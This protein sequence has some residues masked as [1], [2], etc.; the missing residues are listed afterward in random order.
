M[1]LVCVFCL[2]DYLHSLHSP[3]GGHGAARR[4]SGAV[5]TLAVNGTINDTINTNDDPK[6]RFRAGFAITIT[7]PVLR[8]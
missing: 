2:A 8:V 7:K 4:H 3:Q 1:I 6:P 5:A